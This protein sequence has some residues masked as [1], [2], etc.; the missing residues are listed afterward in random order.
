MYIDCHKSCLAFALKTNL[1]YQLY[2]VQ[3]KDYSLKDLLYLCGT[4]EVKCVC[5]KWLGCLVD[6]DN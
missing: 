1:V 5:C 2:W 3:V 4:H 6:V